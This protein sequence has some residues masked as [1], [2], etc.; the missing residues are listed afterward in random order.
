MGVDGPGGD[1]LVELDMSSTSMRRGQPQP[2]LLTKASSSLANAISKLG[3][4][5]SSSGFVKIGRGERSNSLEAGDVVDAADD[6]L[7]DFSDRL[8]ASADW[9]DAGEGSPVNQLGA[10]ALRRASQ[11]RI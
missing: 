9:E 4:S 10:R 6:A 2:P 3:R 5:T 11:L 8:G 1:A 7:A